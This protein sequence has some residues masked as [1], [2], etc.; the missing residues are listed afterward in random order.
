[1]SN[2]EKY[3][4][5]LDI[6]SSKICCIIA[7]KDKHDIS[8]VIGLGCNE[9]KGISNGVVSDFNTAINS[10]SSAVLEAEKQADIKISEINISLSSKVISI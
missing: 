9:A 2:S 1:M 8:K 10:I 5:S 6:G 3:L 7:S 4:A